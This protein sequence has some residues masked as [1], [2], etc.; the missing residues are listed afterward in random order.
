MLRFLI[1]H[2]NYR[3]QERNSRARQAMEQIR[4]RCPHLTVLVQHDGLVV[5]HTANAAPASRTYLLPESG[6]VVLGQLFSNVLDGPR[7]HACTGLSVSD[8]RAIQET[9]GRHLCEKFWGRY[10]G[11]IREDGGR[12]LHLLRDPTG[13]IP[14]FIASQ[15]GVSVVFSHLADAIGPGL[16]SP[17]VDFEYIAAY[18]WH[19]RLVT[20]NTGLA[21]VQRVL[22]GER[23]TIV[24]G[25]RHFREFCWDPRRICRDRVLTDRE[26]AKQKIHDVLRSCVAAWSS[27]FR[28][29]LHLL[30]GGLDSAVV[31]ACL[32]NGSGD[33]SVVCQTYFTREHGGDERSFARRAAS[34]AR[35]RLIES[36]LFGEGANL[37][38]LFHTE[39][40]V[41]PADT[42]MLS[43]T[44]LVRD[45]VIR[46]E[47]I[48]AV[49]SGQGGDHFFQQA[50]TPLIAADYLWYRGWHTEFARVLGDT[51]RLTRLPLWTVLRVALAAG[52]S[53]RPVDPYRDIRYPLLLT[54]EARGGLKRSSVVHPWLE[55]LDGLPSGKLLQIFHVIDSQHLYRELEANA[56]TV[57]PLASQPIIELCLRIPSYILAYRGTDRALVRDAFANDLPPEIR[58]RRTKGTTASYFTSLLIANR[59]S[60]RTRL[61]DGQL[62]RNGILSRRALETSL[63]EGELT[64]NS[65]LLFPLLNALKAELWLQDWTQNQRRGTS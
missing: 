29:V 62:A 12:K 65:R 21:N 48:Q 22:A 40:S 52:L 31:L 58:D 28:T 25:E 24:E 47:R 27:Q 15:D 64:R 50:R 19:H 56:E 57:H 61:L 36:P 60:I 23:L 53:H 18:L 35:V 59:A 63:R 14:C 41:S 16:M 20:R 42:Y 4:L 37:E 9:A 5:Y 1:L 2:W 54:D 26:A 32:P 51:A 17:S 44:K 43:E 46:S 45:E 10:V 30:S 55:R 7:P 3:I 8:G 33:F 49:F 11:A 39:G 13:A 38:D 34:A 6:G